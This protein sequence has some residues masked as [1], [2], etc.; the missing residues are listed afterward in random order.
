MRQAFLLI[1]GVLIA[2][3]TG[4]SARPTAAPKPAPA[5]AAVI[6]LEPYLDGDHFVFHGKIRDRDGLF[7]FDT[8]GGL[9]AVTPQSAAIIACKPWGRLSGFRMRG[10]RVDSKRCDSVTIDAGA[11][12]LHLPTTAIWDLSAILP[13]D[14]P[15]LAGS[16][17]LD[18]FAGQAVTLDLAGRRL[19]V[20]TPQSLKVRTAHA[21]ELTVHMVWEAEGYAPSAM[22][23]LDEPQGRIWCTL[24]SGN[25]ASITLARHV[26]ADFGLDPDRKTSQPLDVTLP[27]GV[28]LIG[29]VHVADLIVDCNIGAPI[30][31]TWVVTFDLARGRVWVSPNP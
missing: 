15:P 22:V 19:I 29:K 1:L 25:D 12:V 30:L 17:G 21:A 14:A 16:V 8:G 24:D 3:T 11:T 26:A 10:D 13:K 7:Q 23:A 28:R 18:A 6:P 27:G 31:R 5:P 2:A 20:E 9:T 4:L